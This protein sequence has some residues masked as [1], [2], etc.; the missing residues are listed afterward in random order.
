MTEL[1]EYI[2]LAIKSIQSN[3]YR[4]GD[5]TIRDGIELVVGEIATEMHGREESSIS[6][7]VHYTGTDVVFAM[8]DQGNDKG[9]LRLYDTVH[10]N[11]PEEGRFLLRHWDVL[12]EE[13]PWMWE[14]GETA[15]ADEKAAPSLK[16]QVE[17]G[18]YPGHAY[19]LSFVPSASN[20][21]NNDRL[22]FWR[23]YGREGAGCSLSIPEAKL[24]DK[25]KCLLTPYRV[26]YGP[27]AVAELRAKLQE[28]VFGPIE[29]RIRGVDGPES[30]LFEA[31][32]PKVRRELQ[33]FRYLYKDQAYGHEG[34]YRLVTMGSA[35]ESGGEPTYEQGTNSRGEIVFRHYLTHASLY[36]QQIFGR[37]SHIV[38]GPTVPHAQNVIGTID[39]FLAKRSISGTTV[40]SSGISYRGR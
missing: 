7:L 2:Q 6:H 9:G 30:M 3:R 32:Q 12:E 31:A 25:R 35:Q 38:L 11:D 27:G 15:E 22:V 4:T 21:E 33:L 20:E 18:I 1:E 8:L 36:S 19:V 23:E 34:E 28:R 40:T 24:F 26:R 17:Q 29:Q 16:E 10:A 5:E 13:W 37:E 14:E 39:K